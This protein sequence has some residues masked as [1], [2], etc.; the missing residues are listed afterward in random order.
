MKGAHVR[1]SIR[2]ADDYLA[3]VLAGQNR[4]LFDGAM[5]TMMQR[6][7]LVSPGQ[8]PDLLNLDNPSAVTA[9]HRAYVEAGSQ[10]VTT[11]TFGS[12]RLKLGSAQRVEEVYTAAVACARES[13]ARYVA[14]DIGPTGELL[15][16]YGDLEFEEAY[17][18]FAEAAKAADAS[19]ADIIIIE[20]M[21]DLNE[22]RAAATAALENSSLP[23]FATMTFTEHGRTLMGDL[24]EDAAREIAGLGVDALGLNCSLGPADL[25]PLACEMLEAVKVPVIVQ[26]NAGLPT[27]VDGQTVYSVGPD[28]YADAVSDILEAGVSIVGGCCGTDPAY[29]R[30]LAAILGVSADA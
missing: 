24:A 19:G 18:L 7:D 25:K 3:G 16:P 22:M 13:G 2:I 26:A 10:V 6:N 8:A 23:V 28:E 29:I 4:L 9:I 15:D 12:N 17:E 11:N 20:T 5:G 1:D 21:A 27:L 14:A 30:A